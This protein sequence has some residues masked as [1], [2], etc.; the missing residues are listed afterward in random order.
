MVQY[1]CDKC[2][3]STTRKTEYSRHIKTKKHLEKVKL[4]HDMSISC[5]IVVQQI[6]TNYKCKYCENEYASQSSR[7]KHMKNCINNIA[8]DI[9][10]DKDIEIKD[11]QLETLENEVKIIKKQA[12]EK[13]QLLKKQAREKEKILKK[14]LETY[15]HLIQTMTTQQTTNYL[16]YIVQNYPNAPAL[17]CKESYEDILDANTMKLID[18]ISMYHYD[19]KL[20]AFIGEYIIKI[21]TKK[22]PKNQSIWTTDISRLTYIISESCK[23]GNNWSYDKKGA[24]IKKLII[25]PALQYI[26]SELYKYCQKNGGSTRVSVLKKLIAAN[27]TIQIIDSGELLEKINKFMAPEFAVTTDKNLIV[28]V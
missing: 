9:S 22:E 13:E 4:H 3:F 28:K 23:N 15:E 8:K 21:Y 20:V 7:S 26:R 19:N 18:V 17:E 27:S 11:I 5:P 25:E 6:S 10:K 12:E 2:V 24:K 1:T 16:N 14:Q